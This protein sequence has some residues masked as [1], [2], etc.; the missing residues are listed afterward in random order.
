MDDADHFRST[1][2]RAAAAAAAAAASHIHGLA[3]SLPAQA[4]LFEQWFPRLRDGGLYVIEDI[5]VTP[6]PWRHKGNTDADRIPHNNTN[7]GKLCFFPQ[8]PADHPFLRPA[9]Q[10]PAMREALAG[11]QWFFSITGTH[12]GGGL[13]MMMWVVK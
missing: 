6:V 1:Q 9:T 5:F 12:A 4:T 13:D 11:R 7:C 8:R 3:H 2:A 10:P